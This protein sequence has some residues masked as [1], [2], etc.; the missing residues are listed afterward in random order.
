MRMFFLASL[1]FMTFPAH[2]YIP[3][4]SFILEEAAK[5]H[6]SLKT[7]AMDGVITDLQD[8]ST[9]KESLKID[10]VKGK[11]LATYSTDS[12]AI[13]NYESSLSNLHRFGKFWITLGVDPSQSRFRQALQEL[14]VVPNE[15]T[16]AK[17]MRIGKV[18]TW[19]WGADPSIQFLKDEFLP[20]FYQTG[21]GTPA[22]QA[23]LLS[24]YTSSSFA[25]RA[26]K[27]VVIA[28]QGKDAFR[29]EMKSIK[30]NQTFKFQPAPGGLKSRL[31][32]DWATLVR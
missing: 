30:I 22:S 20:I 10:F 24:D 16:E 29:F 28:L 19:G 15:Q 13:G 27:E 11:M 18:V 21:E 17:L 5:A 23:I 6:D 8:Q 3:P 31:A 2:A 26:P 7:I 32:K 9:L 12:E 1:W 14:N 25:V 4:P